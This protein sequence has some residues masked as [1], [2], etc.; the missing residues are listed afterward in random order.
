MYPLKRARL[1]QQTDQTELRDKKEEGEGKL[2]EIAQNLCNISADSHS[3]RSALW[4]A[5]WI[6]IKEPDPEGK[7]A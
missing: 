3:H 7:K 2:K 1:K 5:F 6:R 4:E